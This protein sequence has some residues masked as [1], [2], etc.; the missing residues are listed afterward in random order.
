MMPHCLNRTSVGLK[1]YTRLVRQGWQVRPQSN[2]RGIESRIG[3]GNVIQNVP[4]LN[5]TSVGLKAK[6][7]AP[8]LQNPEASIEPAW[9]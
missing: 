3:R 9:D 5:R 2:Q 1:V 7:E 8:G 4:G 6:M